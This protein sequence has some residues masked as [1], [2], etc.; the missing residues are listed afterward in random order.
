M[1]LV[2][3]KGFYQDLAAG[4]LSGSPDI[5]S[6]LVMPGFSF[7]EDAINMDDG[8]LD[9]YDDGSYARLDCGSVTVAYVDA[10]D[11]LRIDCAN[12]DYGTA[13]VGD[14]TGDL[15]RVVFYRHVG[16]DSANVI[17][18][19]NDVGVAGATVSAGGA[20]TLIVPDEG[21]LEVLQAA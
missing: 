3:Y 15:E 12:G 17:L 1:G 5:R 4:N 8:T 6:A 9:E 21:I 19:S 13:L 7:D 2:V 11:L 16:A 18:W 10:D 20:L 14:A